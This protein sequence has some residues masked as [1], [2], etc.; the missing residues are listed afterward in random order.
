MCSLNRLSKVSRFLAVVFTPSD[1]S[2]AFISSELSESVGSDAKLTVVGSV[3]G[4]FS[5]ASACYTQSRA[6]GC[7]TSYAASDGGG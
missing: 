2:F 3:R 5:F 4:Y 6:P 7:T 1:L